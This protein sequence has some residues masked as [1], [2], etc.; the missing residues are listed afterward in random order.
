MLTILKTTWA[1]QTCLIH[2]IGYLSLTIF[3]PILTHIPIMTMS[4]SAANK[5]IILNK[6]ALLINNIKKYKY[7]AK[8]LIAH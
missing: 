1:K 6:K 8:R 2:L 5:R 3:I 4:Q 7:R